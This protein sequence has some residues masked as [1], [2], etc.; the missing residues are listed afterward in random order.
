[1]LDNPIRWNIVIRFFHFLKSQ[2]TG[3][4]EITTNKNKQITTVIKTCF[5]DSLNMHLTNYQN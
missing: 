1:M 2:N 3:K 4:R 5:P